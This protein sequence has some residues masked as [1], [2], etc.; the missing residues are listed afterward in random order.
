MIRKV[1][2]VLLIVPA[3]FLACL[4]TILGSILLAQSMSAIGMVDI[5]LIFV[6]AV[7]GMLLIPLLVIRSLLSVLCLPDLETSSSVREVHELSITSA[8][9]LSVVSGI[10]FLGTGRWSA[11]G[12]YLA[13]GGLAFILHSF[14]AR[15]R[16]SKI[17]GEE[18]DQAE[19][20]QRS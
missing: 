20:S 11:G 18:R 6:E 4:A 1:L 14:S 2:A 9:L 12:I 16:A 19:L 3:A 5:A 15:S 13:A 10:Y 17:Q 8:W 7:L